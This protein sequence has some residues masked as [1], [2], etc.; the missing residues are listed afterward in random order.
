MRV[1]YRGRYSIIIELA[2]DRIRWKF[3]INFSTGNFLFVIIARIIFLVTVDNLGPLRLF[4]II[5]ITFRTIN[6]EVLFATI[7]FLPISN[8]AWVIHLNLSLKHARCP[9]NGRN[10]GITLSIYQSG[11]IM[12]TKFWNR[13]WCLIVNQMRKISSKLTS[14]NYCLLKLLQ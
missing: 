9:L 11:I 3:P 13:P 1:K 5:I 8:V 7:K 6:N 12:K 4:A 2:M 10:H 14:T